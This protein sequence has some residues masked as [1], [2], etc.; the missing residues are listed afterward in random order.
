MRLEV[1][2][3]EAAQHLSPIALESLY[4]ARFDEVFQRGAFAR[5]I[6]IR[7]ISWLLCSQE[8][9]RPT[10]FLAA[11]TWEDQKGFSTL[12]L[13]HLVEICH[14]LII[15][16]VDMDVLRFAHVSVQE[17]LEAKPLFAAQ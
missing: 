11:L 9:L 5:R 12:T 4:A 6:A 17:Y 7:A 3:R 10:A 15:L 8:A 16:D 13:S 1:D 2:V 14:G